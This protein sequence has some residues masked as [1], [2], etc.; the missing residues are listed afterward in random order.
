MKNWLPGN[1]QVEPSL[2]KRHRGNIEPG[3]TSG[4][5]FPIDGVLV[6][7]GCIPY[8]FSGNPEQLISVAEGKCLHGAGLDTG[9]R[10]VLAEAAVEAEI[11]FHDPGLEG[12]V[13]P[14][15]RD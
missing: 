12:T 5:E 3:G 2:F 6:F 11:A 1:L 14:E 7:A 15:S 8:P 13:I 9:R 4:L 10:F